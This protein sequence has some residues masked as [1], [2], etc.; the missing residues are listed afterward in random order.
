VTTSF[1][2]LRGGR[3]YLRSLRPRL[4]M[5]S[6]SLVEFSRGSDSEEVLAL[7]CW[8]MVCCNFSL[9]LVVRHGGFLAFISKHAQARAE[10]AAQKSQMKNE[11]E[12]NG[13]ISS[14]NACKFENISKP[15]IQS[16]LLKR[17]FISR[18]VADGER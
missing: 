8:V 6:A 7:L 17:Y 12:T 10:E 4:G 11:G 2:F 13:L 5:L 14:K 9:P 18:T 15:D 1:V 16:R 3:R